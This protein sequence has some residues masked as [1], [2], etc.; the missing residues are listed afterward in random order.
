MLSQLQLDDT[1]I[2]PLIKGLADELG[3]GSGWRG[4]PGGSRETGHL[5]Q[6]LC[7]AKAADT[8]LH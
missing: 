4:S 5:V 1:L 2:G 3:G 6:R 8:V 7:T